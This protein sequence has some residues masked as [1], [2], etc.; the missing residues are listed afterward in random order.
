MSGEILDTKIVPS[1]K[2][3]VLPNLDAI[4]NA[5]QNGQQLPYG[6]KVLQEYSVRSKRIYGEP[7]TGLGS[8]RVSRRASS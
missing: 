2:T 4:R 7:K 3:T 6:V 1:T 5:Y 8:I